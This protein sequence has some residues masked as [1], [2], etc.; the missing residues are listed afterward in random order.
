MY[1]VYKKPQYVNG[2][3]QNKNIYMTIA[4]LYVFKL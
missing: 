3:I 4:Y 2:L 1:R